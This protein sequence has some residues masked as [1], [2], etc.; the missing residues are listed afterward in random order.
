[1]NLAKASRC[2]NLGEPPYSREN[3]KKQYRRLALKYHPDKNGDTQY[4]RE[5]FQ[6]INEANEFFWLHYPFPEEGVDAAKET[7][8][9]TDTKNTQPSALLFAALTSFLDIVCKSKLEESL[10]PIQFI[11]IYHV[12]LQN[13][14]W[15][16]W[17]LSPI[18]SDRLNQAYHGALDRI[19]IIDVNPSLED[20]FQANVYKLCWNKET[21]YVPLWHHEV[22]F[23]TSTNRQIIVRCKTK[24]L[25]LE[26]DNDNNIICH[27]VV[28]HDFEGDTVWLELS[29]TR[30]WGIPRSRLRTVP[31][32]V[33]CLKG[34]GIPRILNHSQDLFNVTVKSDI[35]AIVNMACEAFP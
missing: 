18:L 9:K 3:V 26:I 4:S 20:L 28:P 25:G 5:M 15:F 7:E 27:V 22:I 8:E 31:I 19:D 21:F 2:L 32:Q 35:Y 24:D 10:S 13:K 1:M 17:T 29:A 34:C 12:F 11:N 14:E 23:E 6:Q 30:K 16:S 33:Y